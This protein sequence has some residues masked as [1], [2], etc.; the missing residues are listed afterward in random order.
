ML[1]LLVLYE[2]ESESEMKNENEIKGT[3]SRGLISIPYVAAEM[4]KVGRYCARRLVTG[5]RVTAADA[6]WSL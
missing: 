4:S 1:L 6:F 3:G 5:A 2:S